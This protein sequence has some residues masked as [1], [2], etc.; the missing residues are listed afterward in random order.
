MKQHSGHNLGG[1]ARQ[2]SDRSLT[3]E[4]DSPGDL[5][6]PVAPSNV[7]LR[8]SHVNSKHRINQLHPKTTCRGV[9]RQNSNKSLNV[10]QRTSFQIDDKS[11]GFLLANDNSDF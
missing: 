11:L 7:P 1:L 8:K 3:C 5:G 6:G 9:L 4:S 2:A 10:N